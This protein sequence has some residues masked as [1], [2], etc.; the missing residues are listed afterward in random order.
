M[1]TDY[2]NR[3]Q[4]NK[5]YLRMSY[6]NALALRTSLETGMRIGDV[7]AL[8]V[9]DL[10][11]RTITY[12][13]QKT[14]KKGKAVISTDLANRLKKIAGKKYIF[15][16]R[17]GNK[18]RTRQAVWRDVKRASEGLFAENVAPHSARKTFAVEDFQEHGLPHTQK[19]L[20]HDRADTTILYAF[21]DSLTGGKS[22]ARQLDRIERVVNLIYKT[23]LEMCEK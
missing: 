5:L 16:G 4:Y 3:E 6:E 11:G 23:L 7:L 9:E 15:E 8:C 18:P 2:I 22:N 17:F 1:R 13:A 14:N 20:Q 21:A 10:N 12:T 19:A